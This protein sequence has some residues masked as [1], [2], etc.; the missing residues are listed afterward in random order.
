VI[1]IPASALLDNRWNQAL[2]RASALGISP[3]EVA[4]AWGECGPDRLLVVL[5]ALAAGRET[6]WG[7]A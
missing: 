1:R 7:A 5:R 2:D 6:G 4:R 3:A